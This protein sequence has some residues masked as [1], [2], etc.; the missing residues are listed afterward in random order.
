MK[1]KKV[2]N[3]CKALYY[4]DIWKGTGKRCHFGETLFSSSLYMCWLL[5][6]SSGYSHLASDHG[7]YHQVATVGMFLVCRLEPTP[8]KACG[9][10]T[11]SSRVH[12]FQNSMAI[13]TQNCSGPD[14]L[15]QHLYFC[16]SF[17]L[18]YHC[19]L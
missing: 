10:T 17:F 15:C 9:C 14:R 19:A 18:Y 13:I 16:T 6:P 11:T 2:F 12:C 7:L 1:K 3:Y 5:F 4:D 8:I